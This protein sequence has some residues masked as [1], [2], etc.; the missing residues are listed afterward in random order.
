MLAKHLFVTGIVQGVGFRPYVYG[1][2]SRLELNGWVKNTSGGVE[3]VVQGKPVDIQG[4]LDSFLVRLPPLAHVDKLEVQEALPGRYEGFEIR[5]SAAV[6]GAFQPVSPDIAI[7]ADCERELFDP[8]NRRYLYPFINCTNCG[9]RLT[10][11][12]DLPYDRAQTTM[13]G[14]EMCPE[15]RHEYQDPGDRRFHAQP[16]AC[17]ACGPSVELRLQGASA[18]SGLEAIL[19][20]RRQLREGRIIAIKGLGGFHLA[21][22]A[23]DPR[24]VEKLRER[25]GR[26]GKPFALMAADLPTVATLCSANERELDVLRGREKPIVLLRRLAGCPACEGAAPGLD[27]LGVMLPYTP[28][29][30]LLLNQSDPTLAKEP[31]PSV[32]VMTSG[33]LSEE[34]IATANGEA[35]DRLAPLVD[36]FLIHNRDIHIRCDDSVVRVQA[37][38]GLDQLS[39]TPLVFLRRSR[40]FAP[41]PVRL[42][43]ETR[44]TLAVGG[45]LKNAFCLTRERYAFLSH[46]IGDMENTETYESFAQGV[47]QFSRLF[48]VEPELIAHDLHPN[49]FTT[50]Y[51]MGLT[52]EVERVGVQ[53][54]HAHIAG[55][56]A[57]NGLDNHQVIGLSFDGTGYGTDGAIWGG[58]LLVADYAGFER[59]GRLEYLPLPG[60]DAAIRHPWRIAVAYAT[61][62]GLAIDDLPFLQTVDGHDCRVVRS[63]VEKW[64][65]TVKT[66]S[67]GRLFDAVASLAGVRNDVS[68]EAQAAIE[69]EVLSR[70]YMDG[71]KPYPFDVEFR[72]GSLTLGLRELLRAVVQ[73]AQKGVSA[74]LIG[75][76]FHKSI[77]DAS[78]EM[79]VRIAEERNLQEAALSG[80][81]WQNAILTELVRGGLAER[82][83]RIHTHHQAPTNDGGLALGQAVVANWVKRA[84][85]AGSE[86]VTMGLSADPAL[87]DRKLA[88]R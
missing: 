82:G 61:S 58:E 6:A 45:E 74:G 44:P 24:A 3:I 73:D 42:P 25:K 59:A 85:G 52:P 29:H 75:A 67:I 21:C 30:L 36:G 65:N 51:A 63:Q 78:V 14:F 8:R 70:P 54:H 55:C 39:K 4:F 28:L 66:S 88:I 40:G 11:I 13:A 38:P 43:F 76:R 22:D 86:Q 15:C 56:M 19:E 81:V 5:E 46:H 9:P 64:L 18:A 77:A 57:E 23:S 26:A 2:A 49:Y 27:T 32:L 72:D 60:G 71:A 10:I 17:P 62:L 37:G 34:P 79:C 16:T 84:G 47:S 31:A 83:L 20:T 33:N 1:L 7:C 68:Y 50:H 80:G 35:L 87:E 53:H 48:R 69:L 41:Y 12:E